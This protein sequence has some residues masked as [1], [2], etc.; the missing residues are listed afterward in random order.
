MDTV[1]KAELMMRLLDQQGVKYH[2]SRLSWQTISCPNVMGHSQGDKNPSARVNLTHGSFACMGCGI[3][4][5]AYSVIMA[6]EGV[7]FKTA[8]D[9]IGMPLNIQSDGFVI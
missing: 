5:D 6:I 4:G 8:K 3:R 2:H 7:D 1:D 9:R